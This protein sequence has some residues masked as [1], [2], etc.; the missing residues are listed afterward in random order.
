[1]RGNGSGKWRGRQLFVCRK[2]FATFV[3]IETVIPE[4]DFDQD[5]EKDTT[6]PDGGK[7]MPR[8]MGHH[9]DP[10]RL[11]GTIIFKRSTL[12]LFFEGFVTLNPH[13]AANSAFTNTISP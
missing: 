8:S 11:S 5:P 13:L 7:M 1:M 9:R 4:K 2:H 6:S 10:G 3:D 12:R